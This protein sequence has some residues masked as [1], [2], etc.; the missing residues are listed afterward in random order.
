[1][2]SSTTFDRIAGAYDELWT[3]TDA[4]RAQREAV[5]RVIEPLFQTGD[6]ILDI[7]CGTGEDAM[8]LGRH[9]IHVSAIDPSGEMVRIASSRGVA[10]TQ[11]AVE[12]LD[13][14]HATYDGAL[15]NFGALNCTADLCSVADSLQRLLR[16]RRY[17][18]ICLLNRT[19]AWEMVWFGLKMRARTAFRRLRRG[20]VSTSLGLL[21]YYPS[22]RQVERA[23]ESGFELMKSVGV[24]VCVPPSYVKLPAMIVRLAAK[25]DAGVGH[26]P[27]LRNLGDHRVYVFRRRPEC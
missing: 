17:V 14:I 27:L 18:V 7:G 23:F 20:G 4:G 1:M 24:G 16:P 10:A 11:L 21:V 26:L 2:T 22:P 8:H 9:G 3:T 15:S 12:E 25:V 5:W 19:C 6:E 13:R